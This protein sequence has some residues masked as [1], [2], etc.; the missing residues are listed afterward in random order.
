M[1][2][3]SRRDRVQI[4]AEILDSCLKP[5]PKTRVMCEV[6]LSYRQ[7]QSY[8][9]ETQELGLIKIQRSEEKYMTTEKGFRFLQKWIEIQ[10][11]L[12][13]RNEPS[14]VLLAANEQR[15]NEMNSM[16]R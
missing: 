3:A 12:T 5:I 11:I 8:L 6:N 4:I 16:N 15:L 7:L 13:C 14:F 1:S 10:Q 2:S 9:Y